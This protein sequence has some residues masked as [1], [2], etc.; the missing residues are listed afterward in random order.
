[1]TLDKALQLGWKITEKLMERQKNGHELHRVTLK[2][3]DE[4][5]RGHG[6]TEAD[7]VQDAISKIIIE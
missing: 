4:D 5:V 1:M 2:K 3:D 6:E 7:A